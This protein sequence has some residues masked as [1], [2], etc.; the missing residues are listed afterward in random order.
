MLGNPADF[1]Q[2]PGSSTEKKPTVSIV[3]DTRP[4]YKAE[5]GSVIGDR[6]DKCFPTRKSDTESSAG[7]QLGQSIL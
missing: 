1:A 2:A 3:I 5:I 7:G 4:R 6:N